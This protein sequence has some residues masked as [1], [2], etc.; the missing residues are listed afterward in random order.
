[1]IS[2]IK[3]WRQ[4]KK[5]R[6]KLGEVGKIVSWTEIYSTPK[7]F[8]KHYSYPVVLVKYPNG[9]KGV[10]QLVDYQN[11]DLRSGTK[12]KT[13]LRKT[14]EVKKD[15]VIVYGIKFRPIK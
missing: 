9:E 15:E 13:V 2:S 8:K 11:K 12:V 10:G 7:S 4:Q 6:H 14:R 3:V 1:M 5:I